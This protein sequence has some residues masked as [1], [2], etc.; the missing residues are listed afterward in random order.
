MTKVSACWNIVCT[1]ADPPHIQSNRFASRSFSVPRTDPSTKPLTY[2]QDGNCLIIQRWESAGCVQCRNAKPRN[3]KTWYTRRKLGRK[4][5]ISGLI[6]H[7]LPLWLEETLISVW[8]KAFKDNVVQLDDVKR[9]IQHA[10]PALNIGNSEY[11]EERVTEI[12]AKKGRRVLLW[13]SG[14]RSLRRRFIVFDPTS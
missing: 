13:A 5:N 8:T 1:I 9:W 4:S 6:T 2:E 7:R 14:P 10:E 12:R 3:W 11:K